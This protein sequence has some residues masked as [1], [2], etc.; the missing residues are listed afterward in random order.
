MT[1]QVVTKNFQPARVRIKLADGSTI[2]GE[3]NLANGEGINRVSDLFTVRKDQFVVVSR[4]SSETVPGPVL[5][6]N[7]SSILWV[8]PED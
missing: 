8:S 6:L 2:R 3:V 4:I 5:I 7:K 1:I